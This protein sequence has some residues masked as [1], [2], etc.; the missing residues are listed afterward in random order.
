MLSQ[1]LL[2][3]SNCRISKSTWI[4]LCS[5][6]IIL[7]LSNGDLQFLSD[8]VLESEESPVSFVGKLIEQSEVSFLFHFSFMII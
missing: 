7:S 2:Y 6:S 3:L 1:I 5:L 8:V 4:A